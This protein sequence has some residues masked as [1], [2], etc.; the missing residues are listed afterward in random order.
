MNR[1]Q[2]EALRAAE[3]QALGKTASTLSKRLNPQQ[4]LDAKVLASAKDRAAKLAIRPR[5]IA[6]VGAGVAAVICWAVF[7]KP[8]PAD[9]KASPAPPVAPQKHSLSAELSTVA[10][11]LAAAAI[12]APAGGSRPQ[13]MRRHTTT[14][15]EAA[16]VLAGDALRQFGTKALDEYRKNAKA[17]EKPT[18]EEPD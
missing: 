13:S 8:K 18:P 11:E 9:P 15:K 14:A 4:L 16:V 12:L 6:A 5:T 2:L 10:L 3:T 1:D 7:K 17:T